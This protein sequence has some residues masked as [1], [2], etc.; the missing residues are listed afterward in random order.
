MPRVQPSAPVVA[1]RAA[2]APHKTVEIV[3]ERAALPKIKELIKSA[4]KTIDIVAYNFYSESGDVK[5]IAQQLIQKKKDNPNIQIRVF[6]EGDH[7]DG[8][9]RNMKTVALLKAAG[10]DVVV[11]SKNLITHAKGICIDSQTVLAGSTNLTNT[12]LDQNNETNALVSSPAIGKAWRKYIDTLVA[13]PTH[14]H[15]STTKIGKVSLL[16]DDAYYDQLM[17]MVKSCK[18]GD[19]LDA[20][21]YYISS[22]PNDK[23]T[24]ALLSEL[25]KA[26]GRGVTIKMYLEQD[27]SGFAPDI[28]A[29]NRKVAERLR[30]AG[31][32][33]HFDPADKITHA[34]AIVKNKKEALL[35]STNWSASD[36]DGRHQLNWHITDESAA[37][38]VAAW[39]ENK[40]ATETGDG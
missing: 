20:V 16:T 37:A 35:G 4:K 32:E 5:D 39:I 17:T 29:S 23:K 21:M 40:M 3:S 24:Q 36:F 10:I 30:K 6:I 34:K 2:A 18:K 13:D 9:A 27:N 15:A 14:L 12:S 25:E 28:T 31:I 19:T 1:T 38:D 11:D 7:G 26:A 33:I 22:S 8:A